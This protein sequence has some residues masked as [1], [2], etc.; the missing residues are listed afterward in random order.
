MEKEKL[1]ILEEY[2]KKAVSSNKELTDLAIEKQCIHCGS[3]V[4]GLPGYTECIECGSLMT[5]PT[6]QSG[7]NQKED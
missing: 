4:W 6:E 2:I 5:L 3:L 7:L 1:L